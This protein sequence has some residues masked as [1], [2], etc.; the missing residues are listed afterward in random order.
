M[1]GKTEG[2]RR[3]GRQRMRW[4]DGITDSMDMSLNKFWEMVK[5][6]EARRAA[7]HGVAKSQTRLSDWTISTGKGEGKI[8]GF[9]GPSS[10]LSV[11]WQDIT[12]TAWCHPSPEEKPWSIGGP[13]RLGSLN[14]HDLFYLHIPTSWRASFRLLLT[15]RVRVL[16]VARVSLQSIEGGIQRENVWDEIHVRMLPRREGLLPQRLWAGGWMHSR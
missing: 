3:R 6:P 14:G 13:Q 12:W 2:R 1:L 9:A 7:V 10:G 11:C 8:R 16:I 15:W 4:L 5:D